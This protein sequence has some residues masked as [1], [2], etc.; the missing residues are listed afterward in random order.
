MIVTFIY[1]Y[2][3]YVGIKY[4]FRKKRIKLFFGRIENDIYITVFGLSMLY[5]LFKDD[6]FFDL[7]LFGILFVVL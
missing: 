4:I 7:V 3:L 2:L 6:L 5:I 1:E